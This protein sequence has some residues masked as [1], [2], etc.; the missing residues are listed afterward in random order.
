MIAKRT[1]RSP[2]KQNVSND[3]VFQLLS[4]PNN[5]EKTRDNDMKGPKWKIK[6][7]ENNHLR[8]TWTSLHNNGKDWFKRSLS[9]QRGWRRKTV[10][11]LWKNK[12]ASGSPKETKHQNP[13]RPIKEYCYAGKGKDEISDVK[14][15]EIKKKNNTSPFNLPSWLALCCSV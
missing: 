2:K 7:L 4:I 11:T 3:L 14:G 12:T 15:M 5:T 8:P 10:K 9:K 13:K 1:P 6:F